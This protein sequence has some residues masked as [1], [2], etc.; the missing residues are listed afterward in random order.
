VIN[1]LPPDVKSNYIYARKNVG[2][3]RWVLLFAIALIGLGAITTYSLV[4]LRQSTISYDHKIEKA[5][6]DLNKEDY[7]GTQKEVQDISNSFKL[8]VKVLGQEVL[9]SK[10]LQQIGQTMPAKT[11]LTGLNIAQTSGGIDITAVASDYKAAT[12][13]QVNLADPT[14]KIFSKAD[15]TSIKCKGSADPMYPCTVQIR[16]LFAQN[17]PFL[18]INSKGTPKT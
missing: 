5:E 9:F 11:A 2:L 10:L 12:Q 3:R 17:N 8:V 13:V 7:V 4:S 16:A 1:L 18:F 15:I 14:N 6:A